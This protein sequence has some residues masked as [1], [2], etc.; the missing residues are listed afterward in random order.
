VSP[1][2]PVPLAVLPPARIIPRAPCAEDARAYRVQ[3]G[4]Y[5]SAANALAAYDRL[6]G[7]GFRAA[8]ERFGGNYRVVIAGVP[9]VCIPETARRLGAAGF[10]EIWIRPE[11]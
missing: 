11:N 1:E 2:A 5:R 9:A 7:A 6:N 3:A 8:Y 4:S 10:P